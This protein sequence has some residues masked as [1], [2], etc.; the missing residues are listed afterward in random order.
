MAD[1]HT[2]KRII[3]HAHTAN[4]RDSPA[5]GLVERLTTPRQKENS[6]LRNVIPGLVNAVGF[7]KGRGIP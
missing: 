4:K 6:L 7:H 1:I 5:G 2:N 3:K